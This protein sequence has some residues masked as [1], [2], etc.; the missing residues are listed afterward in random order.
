MVP[1]IIHA[2]LLSFFGF[3]YARG[4]RWRVLPAPWRQPAIG[5]YGPD[6]ALK[7]IVK[8]MEGTV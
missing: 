1:G 6:R 7:D 8:M 3:R 2:A 5:M 4:K